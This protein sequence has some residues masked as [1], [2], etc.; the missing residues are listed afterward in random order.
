MQMMITT[1]TPFQEVMAMFWH[2]HFASS[3]TP[4][5]VSATKWM[6]TQITLWRQQGNGN[7]RTMLLAMARDYVMLR[8]LDGVSNSKNAPNENFAR[9][10]WELFTLGVDNG[11]T[12]ADIV[13]AAKAW[14]G[15]RDRFDA[16]TNQE[17]AQFDTT[18]HD[19]NSKTFFGQT[20]AAQNTTDDYQRVVD[21][22]V[23]NRP[24]AEF[25]CRKLYE[26]FC[27]PNP[28][29][30][31]TDAMAAL[32]RTNAY[33]L[34]PLLKALFKSEAFF[35]PASRAGIVKNPV[36]HV[37]GFIRSTG[38]LPINPKAGG[39]P[40]AWPNNTLRTLDTDLTTAAMRPTQPPTVNGWPIGDEWL[41]S[42]NMLDR[43]N[44]I[45]DCINDRTDQAAA[46]IS[47]TTLYPNAN[48]TA[49][50][51][52]DALIDLFHIAP[53]AAERLT[54]I[55][56]LGHSATTNGVPVVSAFNALDA[57]QQSERVRG[58]L[59]ILT[60]HPTYAVR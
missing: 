3:S 22:T 20:I 25:I 26:Y 60:Q 53:T 16:V 33:D 49:T 58:L 24:V 46:G 14:T 21:I 38:L 47:V 37:I 48:P 19:P 36:E 13:Q 5:E 15:Y 7:L 10:F 6:R 51:L 31:P 50:E 42:Q 2:D 55:D 41:S 17:F 4:L 32:L 12:Q 56:Y 39:D 29:T 18:L 1:P 52:V 34:K 35:S 9:E 43:G 44:A 40:A 45:L 28:T 23:D 54:Y 11:Y 30:I 57:T 8:W 59:Y 27:N